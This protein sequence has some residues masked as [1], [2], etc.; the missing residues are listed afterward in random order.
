MHKKCFGK[1]YIQNKLPYTNGQKHV[2][3]NERVIQSLPYTA[4][5]NLLLIAF[6]Q[7]R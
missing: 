2:A 1:I 4:T 5:M 3:S 6:S 7:F